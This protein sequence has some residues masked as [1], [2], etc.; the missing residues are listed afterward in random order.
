MRD[1]GALI[2]TVNQT[3]S[4]F[5]L[6]IGAIGLITGKKVIKQVLGLNI[7][8]QGALV[9]LIEAGRA[10]KELLLSQSLIVSAL[11]VETVFLTVVL[12]LIINVYRHH[13]QGHTDHLDRLKG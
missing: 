10:H 7:M 4:A 11:V 13:P 9:A 3:L 8:L 6:A 2:G 1:Y 5:L 12:G